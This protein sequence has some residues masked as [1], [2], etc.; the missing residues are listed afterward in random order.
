[1]MVVR[2]LVWVVE[3][4]RCEGEELE[5]TTDR[6]WETS[7]LERGKISDFLAIITVAGRGGE[8]EREREKGRGRE[9]GRERDRERGTFLL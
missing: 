7:V 9:G 1:M 3:V 4:W 5:P 2:L 8:R 6:R